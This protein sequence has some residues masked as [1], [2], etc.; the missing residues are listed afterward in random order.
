[1][2]HYYPPT[3]VPAHTGSMTLEPNRSMS[4]PMIGLVT[5]LALCRAVC[6]HPNDAR[7]M[8]RSSPIGLMNRPKLS[9]PIAMLTAPDAAMTPTTIQP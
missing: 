3:V 8:P 6:A 1:M 5:E 7:P 2:D 9:D 4:Q